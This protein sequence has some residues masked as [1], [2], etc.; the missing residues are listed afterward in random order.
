M[1]EAL[2]EE[3]LLEEFKHN[4]NYELSWMRSLQKGL[5]NDVIAFGNDIG[6]VG[7]ASIT[8]DG[9]ITV[10]KSNIAYIVVVMHRNIDLPQYFGETVTVVRTEA[11]ARTMQR[12]IF[13]LHSNN[14]LKNN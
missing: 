11:E 5:S 9:V 4:I 10:S 7:R 1:K 6:A 13:N 14:Y 2:S 8:K 3:N 12:N